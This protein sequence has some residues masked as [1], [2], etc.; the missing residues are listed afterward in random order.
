MKVEQCDSKLK[1]KGSVNFTEKKLTVISVGLYYL[2]V[3]GI[4]LCICLDRR[5]FRPVCVK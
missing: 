3:T 1:K 2:E 4:I 5:Q